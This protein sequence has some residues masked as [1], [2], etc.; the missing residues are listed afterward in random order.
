MSLGHF[1]CRCQ[2]LPWLAHDAISEAFNT[3]LS[4]PNRNH[5]DIPNRWP[6]A[7]NGDF[8]PKFFGSLVILFSNVFCNIFFIFFFSD[9]TNVGFNWL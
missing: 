7:Q 4:E 8:F 1:W 5:Y 9:D 6:V 3:A 2:A